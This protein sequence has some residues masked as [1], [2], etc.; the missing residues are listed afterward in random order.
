M[1][2]FWPLILV[3][4]SNSVYHICAKSLPESVDPLASLTVTYLI[5]SIFSGILYFVTNRGGAN[6]LHEYSQM[7]WAPYLLGLAI[8]GLE[9]GSMHAYKAGWPVS[10]FQVSSAAGI[11]TILVFI[12]YLVYHEAITVNKLVG[13]ALCL[14]GLFFLNK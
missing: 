6:L 3:V 11:A 13:L 5:G 10:A 9:A 7:N 14:V 4:A 8:V 12:G 1:A 2:Y